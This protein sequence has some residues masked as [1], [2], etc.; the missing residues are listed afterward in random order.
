MKVDM[1]MPQMGESIAEGTI[2]K[3]LKA[4]GETVERDE[5]ILEISTDKVDSEIPSPATGTVTKILV[6]EGETVEVGTVLA[7]IETD[8]AAPPETADAEGETTAEAGAPAKSEAP[9]GTE[10]PVQAEQAVAEREER[11]G[12]ARAERG[13]EPAAQ[14]NEAAEG[15]EVPRR[16]GSRFFSPLV[17]SLAEE[18]DVST[19]ELE[20]L[21]GSGR[22]GRVTKKDLV[23]YVE[24]RK[25]RPAE[26]PRE[27]REEAAPRRPAPAPQAPAA[28]ALPSRGARTG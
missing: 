10:A 16:R 20:K 28:P 17:R 15:E 1:V 6:P 14:E 25:K 18:H 7:Q 13:R 23:A 26:R 4:E 9:A 12:E 19:A 2:L 8:G 5:N 3:W 27:R 24:A 21:D 22:G 11:A